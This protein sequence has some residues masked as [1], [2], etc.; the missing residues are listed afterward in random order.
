MGCLCTRLIC[1]FAEV[2]STLNLFSATHYRRLFWLSPNLDG[3]FRVAAENGRRI[4]VDESNIHFR[5]AA[6]SN[7]NQRIC[8]ITILNRFLMDRSAVVKNSRI[9]RSFATVAI[10]PRFILVTR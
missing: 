2:N 5:L 9:N 1:V 10:P 6:L 8:C 7:S 3:H 4:K